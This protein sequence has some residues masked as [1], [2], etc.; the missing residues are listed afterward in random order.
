MVPE[1]PDMPTMSRAAVLAIPALDLLQRRTLFATRR[2]GT[3]AGR[4]RG[5]KCAFETADQNLDG[6]FREVAAHRTLIGVDVGARRIFRRR[7]LAERAGLGELI[8]SFLLQ[9]LGVE[10]HRLHFVAER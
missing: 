10:L 4:K 6:L 8:Q 2:C 3:P 5:L 9:L 1:A 7:F